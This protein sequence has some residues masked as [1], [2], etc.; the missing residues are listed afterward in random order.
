VKILFIDDDEDD[1]ILT[2]DLLSD[3]DGKVFDMEWVSDY[4]AG[5]SA[6]NNNSY[7]VCILDY[8]LGEHTGLDLLRE[9]ITGG[10][11]TP[12]IMLTGKETRDN[13]IRALQAG[14]TDY[15]HKNELNCQ[16]LERTIRYA[17]ER[18]LS[19]ERILRMAYYDDLTSL[20]NRVLFQDRLK[21]VL[22]HAE[23]YKDQFAVMFLDLDNFKRI[24]D[25][26]DHRIGDLLL[27]DVAKR[28]SGYVRKAD[29]V[30]YQKKHAFASTI[31]RLGG[32]EFTVMLTDIR[33]IQDAGKVS[34]R[35]LDILSQPFRLDNHEVFI[36]ASIGIA[37]YPFDGVD[38]DTLLKN[39]DI[40]MYHAKEQGK[41]NYQFYKQSMNTSAFE[42]L[43]LENSLRKALVREEFIL[44]YQPRMDLKTGAIVG[45]EALIRWNNP[46][47]GLIPPSEFIPIAEETGIIMSIGEWVLKNACHQ[48]KVWQDTRSLKTPV[49]VSIN[50]SGYQFNQDTFINL[51]EKVLD[52]SCLEPE[53]LELEITESV[54]MKNA[55]KT[56]ILLDKLKRMGLSISMDD[57]GTGYSSFSYLKRFPIDIIKID[58]SFVKDITKNPDDAAIVRAILAMA[59]NLKL[60]VVAEGVETEEQLEF[61]REHRCDEIQGFLLSA[62]LSPEEVPEFFKGRKSR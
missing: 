34:Q 22:T 20:P 33:S 28:L 6:I 1:F 31:A 54:I 59:R 12:I 19:N 26:L 3:V 45:T 44:H 4:K 48:N 14:A 61:L 27:K 39:A 24:N 55:E 21:Q 36:T 57:F 47:K 50:L 16:L 41:N 46:E 7:D 25:T 18:K 60:K 62:P 8:Y 49:S 42:R 52:V 53:Y 37:I 10:C 29:T 11:K 17:I 35:M 9:A 40:A 56:I 38:T 2:K 51:V 43:N 5:L 30:A 32:D 13:D 23:R 15:L 58:R